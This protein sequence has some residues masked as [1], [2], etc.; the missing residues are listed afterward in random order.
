MLEYRRVPISKY[1]IG[2]IC[3]NLRNKNPLSPST[4]TATTN[5][6]TY[7]KRSYSSYSSSLQ[8]S[9]P[10]MYNSFE[11]HEQKSLLLLHYVIIVWNNYYL[12]FLRRQENP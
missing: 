7:Y 11:L 9:K 2:D 1:S 3:P 5:R 10:K 8:Q 4:N 6:A 12:L